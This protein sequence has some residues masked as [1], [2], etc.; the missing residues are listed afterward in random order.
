LLKILS[1]VASQVF[2]NP[3]LNTLLIILVILLSL[4]G[5]VGCLAP[6]VP[7]PP[8]NYLAM[9]IFQWT[10]YPF[11]IS[12]LII[13]GVLTLIV[14]LLDYYLP[15]IVARKYGATRA[16]IT[17]SIIGMIIG[18]FFTPIGMIAGIILGAVIGDM[19]GGK[20]PAEAARSGIATFTGTLLSIGLK[21]VLSG[22]MTSMIVYILLRKV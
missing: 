6:A 10:I 2:P 4:A 8:L 1:N 22:I 12:T 20:S 14:L 7:G 13:F 19:I 17:G 16:G 15:V 5:I 9:W 3:P 18:F 21:L 11:R